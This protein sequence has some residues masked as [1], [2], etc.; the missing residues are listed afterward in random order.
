MKEMDADTLEALKGSIKKWEGIVAGTA[1]DESAANC[2]L[3]QKFQVNRAPGKKLC[4]GC[5][6][7][8]ASGDWGCGNTPYEAWE[9]FNGE[10]SHVS[11]I[12]EGEQLTGYVDK[13]P[14]CLRLAT[15][16]LDFLKSLLPAA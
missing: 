15:A 2:P 3:C 12:D 8:D 11:H 7:R 9:Q 5:P 13:C 16:E 10:C 6:V 14:E 4:E 1:G